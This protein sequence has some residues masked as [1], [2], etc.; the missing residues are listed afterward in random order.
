M[1]Q[2]IYFIHVHF[3]Y[4]LYKDK[5]AFVSRIYRYKGIIISPDLSTALVVS[6]LIWSI[7]K[8]FLY[9]YCFATL[10]RFI[11]LVPFTEIAQLT[12]INL[13][14]IILRQR[15]FIHH[16]YIQSWHRLSNAP[17]IEF[18]PIE[19]HS[20]VVISTRTK[21]FYEVLIRIFM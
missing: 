15:H 7:S 16:S 20:F 11:F 13:L 17:Y 5:Q 10:T 21:S 6:A 3:Y 8:L 9:G 4:I 12:E 2:F 14:M 18:L 19:H 1:K